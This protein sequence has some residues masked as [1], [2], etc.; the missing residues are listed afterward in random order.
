M[1]HRLFSLIALLLA[2]FGVFAQGNEEGI[3]EK[4]NEFFATYITDPVVRIIF[5][6][7]EFEINEEVIKVPLVLVWLLAGAL[8]FTIYFRFVNFEIVG[9]A[10]KD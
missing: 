10:S 5:V 4:I 3:D 1:K 9:D 2:N 8:F 7:F 6:S